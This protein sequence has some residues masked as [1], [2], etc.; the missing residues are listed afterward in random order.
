MSAGLQDGPDAAARPSAT[1]P[2]RVGLILVLLLVFTALFFRSVLP[3]VPRLFLRGRLRIS[4]I[5]IRG[6]RGIEWRSKGFSGDGD[7]SHGQEDDQLQVKVQRIYAVLRRPRWKRQP[8]DTSTASPTI[9]SRSLLTI[10]VRGVGIRLARSK[11]DEAAFK[12]SVQKARDREMALKAEED[13]LRM[14]ADERLASLMSSSS[15]A[16]P[17]VGAAAAPSD[18]SDACAQRKASMQA[19]TIASERSSIHRAGA[20]SLHTVLQLAAWIR[21]SVIPAVRGFVLR[22]VRAAVF[23]LTS[24]LP[25]L[26]SLVDV[27]VHRIEVYVQEAEAVARIGRAG[28]E[29][30][31]AVVSARDQ[32]A[33]GEGIS[34][35][36]PAAAVLDPKPPSWS[37]LFSAAARMPNRIGSGARGAASYLMGGLPDGKA[38]FRLRV[39]GVQLF[40]A[41]LDAGSEWRSTPTRASPATGYSHANGRTA[42]SSSSVMEASRPGSPAPRSKRRHVSGH[43]RS[44]SLTQMDANADAAQ[45]GWTSYDWPD[46]GSPRSPRSLSPAPNLKRSNSVSMLGVVSS[47][48]LNGFTDRWADWAL[49]PLADSDFSSDTGWLQG[50]SGSGSSAK[51]GPMRRRAAIPETSRLLSLP[52]VS[53]LQIGLLLGTNFTFRAREMVDLSVSMCETVVGVDSVLRVASILESRKAQRTGWVPTVDGV[54]GHER[55]VVSKHLAKQDE[56]LPRAVLTALSS[57][58]FSVPAVSLT[59][60]PAPR[61]SR[62]AANG[63]AP[64][65]PAR[66]LFEAE[67]TGFHLSIGTS[68]PANDTHQRWLGACGVRDHITLHRA[69][70]RKAASRAG[71]GHRR[72]Q[73]SE[74]RAEQP[75]P[76]RFKRRT[77]VENRRAFVLDVGLASLEVHCGLKDQP[78]ER[79]SELV[80]VGDLAASALSTWTPFGILPSAHHTRRS[81][82]VSF[83][84]DFNE[85][86]AV[87]SAGVG[88]ISGDVRLD[89]LTELVRLKQFYAAQRAA[90]RTRMHIDNH[91]R[92]P[93]EIERLRRVPRLVVGVEVNSV[94]YVVDIGSQGQGGEP[95]IRRERKLAFTMPHLSANFAGDYH[96]QYVKRPD[97]EKRASYKALRRDELEWPLKAGPAARSL[98]EILTEQGDPPPTEE[99]ADLAEDLADGE[100]SSNDVPLARFSPDAGPAAAEGLSIADALEQ[101][102]QLQAADEERSPARPSAASS[103]RTT[104]RDVHARTGKVR[105]PGYT[106]RSR[107]AAE[108]LYSHKYQFEASVQVEAVE[109]YLTLSGGSASSRRGFLQPLSGSESVAGGYSQHHL[110]ALHTLE[111]CGA[112]AVP[113]NVT[114]CGVFDEI[115]VPWI[116][117]KD[118][119][120]NVRGSVEDIDVEMWHPAAINAYLQLSERLAE[121]ST[122]F[123]ASL[124]DEGGK[125]KD[126]QNQSSPARAEPRPDTAEDRPKPDDASPQPEMATALVDR[127]PKGLTIYLS[128]GSAI[129][130]LGGSDPQCDPHLTRGVGLESKRIVVE[131]S[132][133]TETKN[134]AS[135]YRGGW[136]ARGALELPQDLRLQAIALSSRHG[137]AALVRVTFFETGLFPVL[138]AAQAMKQHMEGLEDGEADASKESL[139]RN[140]VPQASARPESPSSATSD[141]GDAGPDDGSSAVFAEGVWDFRGADEGLRHTKRKRPKFRQQDRSNYIFWMPISAFKA[142]IRPPGDASSPKPGQ[143]AVEEVTIT[144]EDSRLVALRVDLLHTYCLLLTASMLKD[145]A[146]RRR[147]LRQQTDVE[148]DGAG[149]RRKPRSSSSSPSAGTRMGVHLNFG[150][151]HIHVAL[152]RNVNLFLRL[153][154]IEIKK[155]QIDGLSVALESVLAAVESP[156][157]AR[158]DLWETAVRLRDFKI[159]MPAV[160][161]GDKR[162]IE[163]NGDS[164]AIQIPFGYQVNQIIDNAS[165]AFKASK[166]LVHQFLSGRTD[167][168]IVPV[169]E[170]PKRLPD[171]SVRIRIFVIAAEDDPFET[172]LNIIW[173]AGCDE[174]RAREEREAAFQVKATEILAAQETRSLASFHTDSVDSFVGTTSSEGGSPTSSNVHG[175]S[176]EAAAENIEMAR[177]ALDAYNS[178]S[179]TRRCRNAK[180][181]QARRQDAAMRRISGRLPARLEDDV[182][183]RIVPASRSAPLFRSSMSDVLIELSEPPHFAGEALRDFIHEQGGGIPRDT[184]FSLLLPIHVRWRMKEWRISLRDYP[185]PMLHV[186]PISHKQ[187]DGLY[188]WDMEADLVVAEQLGGPESIR[189]V[190]AVVVPAATGH[191][192]AIEYGIMVPKVA[193]P[194]KLYG[195]PRVGI[196]TSFPTRLVWGQSVQPAIQDVVRVIDG[197]TS[198]PHDPSPKLGFWDKIPLV[199]HGALSIDFKGEGD[200]NLHLKGSRDPY[201]ITGQAAGWVKCW[202]GGVQIRLGHLNDEKEVFQILSNEYLLAIP[203]LTDYTDAAATGVTPE[204]RHSRSDSRDDADQKSYD[205]SLGSSSRR[206]MRDPTFSKIVLKLTN[207]VKWGAGLH[208]ERTCDERSCRRNPR[209]EGEAFYRE[210]RI[211][212][213]VPHWEVVTKTK[214]HFDSLP[215]HERIDSYRGWRSDHIHFSL[216]VFSPGDGLPGHSAA[217]RGHGVSNNFYFTPLAWAHFWAWMRLFSSAMGLPIRHGSLFPDSAPPSPKFGRHLGTIKYRID[218]QPLFITHQYMQFIKSDWARGLRTFLGIK[219]RLGLF[220]LDLHQ[221]QQ[222]TVK[223][224]PELGAPKI[225]F[226]KPFYEAEVDCTDIDLRMLCAQFDEPT[227]RLLMDG[228]DDFEESPLD[229]IFAGRCSVSDSDL[230]WVDLDDF[231][232]LETATLSDLKPKLKLYPA[233]TCPS[234]NYYRKI[235]SQRERRAKEDEFRSKG[236]RRDRRSRHDSSAASEDRDTEALMASLE[237]SKFGDEHTHACLVGKGQE[238]M[239]IQHKLA[240]QRLAVIRSDI[241]RLKSKDSGR[242]PSIT[243][244]SSGGGTTAEDDPAARLEELQMR[245]RLVLNFLDHL[246][247]LQAESSGN[248]Q[249]RRNPLEA[250]THDGFESDELDLASLYQDLGNF[251]NRYF[252]HNPTLFFSNATRMVLLKYYYSSRRRRGYCHHMTATAVRYIRDLVKSNSDGQGDGDSYDTDGGG[253]IDDG[254]GDGE[255]DVDVNVGGRCGSR[256]KGRRGQQRN[257]ATSHLHG[258]HRSGTVGAESI[259]TGS[260]SA[261][262]EMLQE[263]L[264]NAELDDGTSNEGRGCIV[265]N[266]GDG[267]S[268]EYTVKSSNVCLFLKPQIVLRSDVDDRSTVV[269]TAL[270]A[271][272][273]NYTVLDE[274]CA[275]DSVNAIVL[276]RNFFAL[277]GLQCFHPSQSY[278]FLQNA[279]G[280][281]GFVSVPLET[282]IDLKYQTKDFDRIVPRTNAHVFYDKFNKLRLSDSTR[283][284]AALDED[285]EPKYD[286]LYHR[287]DVIRL[288]CPR[289]TVSA[290]RDH[291][292]A[293]YNVVTD[294]IL[295]RDP[296]HRDHAKRLEEIMFSHDFTEVSGLSE[297]VSALQDRIRDTND[298]ARQYYENLDRLTEQGR[299]DLYALAGEMVD[300]LDELNLIMEAITEAQDSKGGADREK[301]SALRFDACAKDLS[302]NM[303]GDDDGQ[304]LAKLALRGISFAWLNKADN[305]ASN[306]LSLQDLQALSVRP[307]AV[308]AEIITKYHRAPNHPMAKAG[309]FLDAMWSVLPPVGGISIIDYFELKQHPVRI[310]VEMRVGRQIQDYIFGS[311]KQRK[312]EEDRQKRIESEE[313]KRSEQSAAK[314]KKSPLARLLLG[315]SKK[316]S[317]KEEPRSQASSVPASASASTSDLASL[318]RESLD[319]MDTLGAEDD[320]DFDSRSHHSGGRR[321]AINQQTN[322]S[323]MSKDSSRSRPST[324][325]TKASHGSDDE[326]GAGDQIAI[327]RRNA[328]EMRSRAAAYRTFVDVTFKETVICLSYKGEKQK[329]ITDL[330]D[331]V[332]QAP[333]F[334]VHNRTFG[335]IDLAEA[336]KKEVFKAAWA[337]KTTLLK[338]VLTHKPQR[339]KAA[340]EHIKAIR[341]GKSKDVLSPFEI[342]V[343]PPAPDGSSLSTAS[344]LGLTSSPAEVEY[345]SDDQRDSDSERASFDDPPPVSIVTTSA[346]GDPSY[347]RRDHGEHDDYGGGGG[348]DSNDD[349][350]DENHRRRPGGE[351]GGG[352]DITPR[353]TRTMSSMLSPPSSIRHGFGGS[354][355]SSS[356]QQHGGT[357]PAFKLGKFL[358]RNFRHRAESAS[359]SISSSRTVSMSRNGSAHTGEGS[360]SPSSSSGSHH[361]G[362]RLQRRTSDLGSDSGESARRL[363]PPPLVEAMHWGSVRTQRAGS[364]DAANLI[365]RSGPSGG[366]GG[367]GGT[368]RGLLPRRSSTN[369]VEPESSS[370]SLRHADGD[371]T[372]RDRKRSLFDN[373]FGSGQPH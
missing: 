173:R 268:E 66:L 114:R 50:G 350:D 20:L 278:R 49:E 209:C 81:A 142:T 233:L 10:H 328:A 203:D 181:E 311:Q 116:S 251:D 212:D 285:G 292:A 335:Y 272:L 115:E 310:Q 25:S 161:Q 347:G 178:S 210:C 346:D 183:I 72:G 148:H 74:G 260:A 167:S 132:A 299:L 255:G 223:E 31:M 104:V 107:M 246:C 274:S 153:R 358:S 224:K 5:G 357:S 9:C 56:A 41:D 208:L 147:P 146:A 304:M 21:T 168:V 151:V 336:F 228:A 257:R 256:K 12:R 85:E 306:T 90:I 119:V 176:A 32:Q 270:R 302:W 101:M 226:H 322:S 245:E 298:L 110:L 47:M 219:A 339:R 156:K 39:E 329:S 28:I 14:E 343:Q 326:D 267:I 283:T 35:P 342:Q 367:G 349:R 282:L 191:P 196:H 363:A 99:P 70:A 262:H 294:L 68:N 207:G 11:H 293:L 253:D 264:R 344:S 252:A 54:E 214:A 333:R 371:A 250:F 170:E 34:G 60:S 154:R 269:I 117:A 276:R 186:P 19:T 92:E 97:A 7:A 295:Y 314:S 218:L 59:A 61:L 100:P 308:F 193:M 42:S 327:A 150:D 318:D 160:A 91:H 305:S 138:D 58:A 33:K 125:N 271:R 124:F 225:V 23:I 111:L 281:S 370:P 128:I 112:G 201:Q 198:P 62:T 86:T 369:T 261:L 190:P 289:F 297:V 2:W 98:A 18:E 290:N 105:M 258:H 323:V 315:H 45:A 287:M 79:R 53:E 189:H 164:A 238:P 180:A 373:P 77:L 94:E 192:D 26:T 8:A 69:N 241:A 284:V 106:R 296:V 152:P 55:S 199:M 185:M 307:D 280:R 341:H 303:M 145:L 221:R 157:S 195:S 22:F 259:P 48:S 325:A 37:E 331:V 24:S 353:P 127:L 64:Q 76:P 338:G 143:R 368:L 36:A 102:K 71:L 242:A 263:A 80:F 29:F 247:R 162:R 229:D 122:P 1:S 182:P 103:R 137:M 65:L 135:H 123:A 96:D 78:L 95:S 206:Y 356:S 340:I 88:R 266:P 316:S 87:V 6:V 44:G 243:T 354:P 216:S 220:R 184:P 16:S 109:T 227:Q 27:Q 213:R 234:F 240:E 63:R 93:S 175:Q 126:R 194:V 361:S 217:R 275:E 215:E 244:T 38:C 345:A 301:K 330:Y 13:R 52:G 89:H 163:V 222:E 319:S 265:T 188:S 165:V 30:S 360:L 131:Y 149:P 249:R 321:S 174:N 324:P 67:L 75:P 279:S 237:R 248:D 82:P 187:P 277:D 235:D 172:R 141:L 171:V 309:R 204:A 236:G 129:A 320:D 364:V 372:V 121:A 120:A 169:A 136:G 179:W 286:H 205:T 166:Q 139:H 362:E 232:E 202:R 312:E 159:R 43:S 337:Q 348:H 288:R 113:G 118:G 155:N 317:Q 84:G 158:Q 300:L 239:Q 15:E 177:E 130:H 134:N 40:E 359:G 366:S 200:F 352:D 231:V 313:R 291:F 144:S 254:D 230:D 51:G 332:F 365:D 4:R 197:I 108:T 17:H 133:A 57:F 334:G 46:T 140:G 273:H 83:P 211:F 73:S 351:L 3:R 355:S